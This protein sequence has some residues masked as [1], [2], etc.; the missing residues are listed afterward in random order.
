MSNFAKKSAVTVDSRFWTP[1]A[2]VRKKGRNA[3][4]KS[5]VTVDAGFRHKLPA[6]A[7]NQRKMSE[8]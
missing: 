7:Q 8:K 6:R 2:K 1:G 3:T 4:P 5:A